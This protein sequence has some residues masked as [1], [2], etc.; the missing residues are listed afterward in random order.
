MPEGKPPGFSVRQVYFAATS[1]P[2]YPD[3]RDE[4]RGVD[5]REHR[6]YAGERHRRLVGP[7]ARRRESGGAA[8]GRRRRGRRDGRE[9]RAE[10]IFARFTEVVVQLDL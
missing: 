8:R 10:R 9:P 1:N 5:L 3:C 4:P 2:I 6:D 7:R